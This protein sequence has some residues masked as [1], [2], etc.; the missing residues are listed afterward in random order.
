MRKTRLKEEAHRT[1]KE[2]SIV[3]FREARTRARASA[4]QR[5]YRRFRAGVHSA[6]LVSGGPSQR[7]E[8]DNAK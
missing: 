3:A 2:A 5:Y 8:A 6:G 7:P 4:V 1:K